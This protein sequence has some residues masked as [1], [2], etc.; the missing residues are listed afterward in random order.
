MSELFSGLTRSQLMARIRS[1][2]NKRTEVAMIEVLR[3]IGVKGWRR[4]VSIKR[5]AH[6]NRRSS[7]ATGRPFSVRPDF[8]FPKSR[9]ALFVDGCFWHGCSKH[10]THAGKSGKFW[11][12][13]LERNIKRDRLVG[14]VL[15]TEGWKV[16]RIWEHELTKKNRAR[17]LRIMGKALGSII[18]GVYR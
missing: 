1:R 14:R 6:P 3:A 11:I 18:S 4:H 5:Q 2:G 17:L 10:S 15:K 16:V 9:I 8:V 13:K 7:K 12:N